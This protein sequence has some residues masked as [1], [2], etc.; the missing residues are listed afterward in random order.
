MQEATVKTAA[1]QKKKKVLLVLYYLIYWLCQGGASAVP[2]DEDEGPLELLQRPKEYKVR[3]I[4]PNPPP[5][6]PPIL[7]AYGKSHDLSRDL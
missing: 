1:A 6:N 5:L 3:F 7:G 4:F 2:E